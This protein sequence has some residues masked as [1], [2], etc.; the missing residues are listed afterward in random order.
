MR[1]QLVRV[2]PLQTAKVFGV[3][4]FAV[5]LPLCVLMIIPML[6]SDNPPPM[7][8]IGMPLL[9]GAF[10]FLFTLFGAAVY[11]LAAKYVGGIEYT[12]VE[13]PNV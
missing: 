2:S 9:Y 10:G 4:Y 8:I 3:V 6:F 7:F 13:L 11:N 5:T 12:S 1:K